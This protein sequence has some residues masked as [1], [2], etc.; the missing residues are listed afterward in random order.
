MKNALAA[1]MTSCQ[2]SCADPSLGIAERNSPA[3]PSSSSRPG[4]PV[5]FADPHRRGSAERTRTPTGCCASTSQRA[6]ICPGGPPRTSRPSPSRS[7]PAP[8]DPR[9]E[10]PRRGLQRTPTLAPTGRCC[11]DRLNLPWSIRTVSHGDLVVANAPEAQTSSRPLAACTPCTTQGAAWCEPLLGTTK[12]SP[13]Q[14]TMAL[15]PL[16]IPEG[17]TPSSDQRRG[18]GAG[19]RTPQ[20]PRT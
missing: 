3:T 13:V 8:Q 6:P 1:T 19:D 16:P 2:S 11:I 7:T 10:D 18:P 15:P 12:I 5:F 4:I 17:E 14:S 20:P 9:L